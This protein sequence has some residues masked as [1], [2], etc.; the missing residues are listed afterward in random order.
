MHRGGRGRGHSVSTRA[1]SGKKSTSLYISLEKAII[2]TSKHGRTIL[3][4]ITVQSFWSGKTLRKI[5]LK[6]GVNTKRVNRMALMPPGHRIIPLKSNSLPTSRSPRVAKKVSRTQEFPQ[7][8]AGVRPDVIQRVIT[9]RSIL[10]FLATQK[11]VLLWFLAVVFGVRKS[12]L[13]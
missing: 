11:S 7:A 9:S 12:F 10:C 8:S 1:V 3:F 5:V 2:V 13:Q 6:S 4:P